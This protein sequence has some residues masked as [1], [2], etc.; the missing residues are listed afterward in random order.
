MRKLAPADRR[1][2][3]LSAIRSAG[4]VAEETMPEVAARLGVFGAMVSA[5]AVW[6]P[7][8]YDGP[9]ALMVAGDAGAAAERLSGWRRFTTGEATARA[10]AGNHHTML[11]PPAV[12]GLAGVLDSLLNG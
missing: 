11:R 6:Q 7:A 3:V 5:A 8:R 9:L 2:A 4:L 12:S 1:R 10:V